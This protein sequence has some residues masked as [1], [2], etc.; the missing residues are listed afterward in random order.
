M[1]KKR[2]LAF[3]TVVY[4]A[5]LAYIIAGLVWWFIALQRQNRQMT[6]YQLRELKM[7]DPHYTDKLNSLFLDEQRK[8]TGYIGEGST[9]LLLILVGALF[10]YREVRRQIRLQQQQQYFMMAVTHE[11]K[12]PIAVAKLNLET[13][14]KYRL[15][16]TKQQKIIQAALQETGRLDTLATNIL[17]ASQLEGGDYTQ[18]KEE[19]DLSAL[20]SNVVGDFRNRYP[21][22]KWNS[23][24]TPE[25]AITGDT[26]LLQMLISN[27]ITNAMKYSPKEGAITVELKR[28]GRR[29]LLSV[30]DEGPGIPEEEKKK[31]FNKFYRTGNEATRSTQGTGLGLYLCRK[32]ADDHKAH[33]TVS[34]NSPAG[35]I[36]TVSF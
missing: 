15:D 11:L 28:Q 34:D 1:F 27:L 18:A 36:F 35:S 16:E 19:L 31:V 30:K 3:A 8:T 26:L 25:L 13:L 12:T 32:I 14:Q 21:L 22:R 17:I 7:D 33:I 24:I 29:L 10:V 2:R 23:L 9:Y 5:L 4:W 6:I 20:I